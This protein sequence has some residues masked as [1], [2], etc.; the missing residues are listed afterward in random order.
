MADTKTIS[1]WRDCGP[2]EPN[3]I[4]NWPVQGA[5]PFRSVHLHFRVFRY[6]TV[7]PAAEEAGFGGEILANRGIEEGCSIRLTLVGGQVLKGEVRKA[8]QTGLVVVVGEDSGSQERSFE[9]R[10]I[11]KIEINDTQEKGW[12]RSDLCRFGCGWIVAFRPFTSG[13]ELE[14]TTGI[15]RRQFCTTNLT[16][17]FTRQAHRSC[18]LLAQ[19]PRPSRFAA[20]ACR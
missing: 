20:C 11:A 7:Y 5:C 14:P 1:M 8:F 19:G 2:L 10:E 6:S 15:V 12:L 17:A 16:S 18:P 4:S 13:N 3:T 9:Y